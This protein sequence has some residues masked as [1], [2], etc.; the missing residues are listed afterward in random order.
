MTRDTVTPTIHAAVLF[1]DR[2]C[3]LAKLDPAHVC[4]DQ[5]GRVHSPADLA[6]LTLEHVHERY[7]TM[8]KRA[9][10]DLGHLVALCA[11]A[12][13]R[14]PTKTQRAMFR[15]YLREVQP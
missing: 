9:P 10:S 3:V 5:W 14:P 15:A 4:R 8:G 7:G 13:L 11:A 12:N 6:A 2:M 1:R